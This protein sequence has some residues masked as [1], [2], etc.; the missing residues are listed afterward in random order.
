VEFYKHFA[1]LYRQD[2]LGPYYDLV[3]EGK[4]TVDDCRL[5]K[6]MLE[7]MSRWELYLENDPVLG[8]GVRKNR[9]PAGWRV[10]G[11]AR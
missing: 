10:S 3:R 5:G 4:L 2:D 8:E 9:S 11:S 7:V 6:R 1:N